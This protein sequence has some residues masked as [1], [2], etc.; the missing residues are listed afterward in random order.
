MKQRILPFLAAM[1]AFLLPGLSKAQSYPPV[2][3]STATYAAG[4]LVQYGGNWYRAVKALA[5]HGSYPSNG[6][7][8]WEL[9]YVRSNTTLVIGVE[10]QFPSLQDAWGFA[11]E[12]RVADGAYLHFSISTAHGDLEDAFTTTFNL[13]HQSGSKISI[14]GDDA[15]KIFLGGPTGFA[16]NGLNLDT[17]HDIASLS[18]VTI[19]GAGDGDGLYVASGASISCSNVQ[20]AFFHNGVHVVQGAS[21]TLDGSCTIGLSG[22]HSAE[23]DLDGTIIF[24]AGFTCKDGDPVCI[25]WAQTGGVIQA[26]GSTL[27]GNSSGNT[28]GA[29]AFEGGIIDVSDSS[30]SNCVNGVE[31][32]DHGFLHGYSMQFSGNKTD[33]VAT[34]NGVVLDDGTA[35]PSKFTDS[36]TGS[37]ID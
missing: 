15:S 25:L 3:T 5:A 28:S 21:A 10:Q 37:V 29:E 31:A 2:W 12:A 9:N 14:I 20:I 17:V 34:Q 19:L 11:L 27:D 13:D 24:G 26:I 7:G 4:D 16:E 6:F 32:S 33:I 30:I 35:S 22:N 36:G 18:N 8:S 23:A 1:A